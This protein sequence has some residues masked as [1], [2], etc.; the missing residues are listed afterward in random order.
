MF[1]GRA[2][3]DVKSNS[4]TV[5]LTGSIPFLLSIAPKKV[6]TPVSLFRISYIYQNSFLNYFGNVPMERIVWESTRNTVLS[7]VYS[8]DM[9]EI[10][11]STSPPTQRKSFAYA[12]KSPNGYYIVVEAVGGRRNPNV[13]P[14]MLLKFSEAKWNDMMD[15]GKTLGEVL[16]ENDT[17]LRDALDVE[18]N[19]KNRVT[20]AQFASKEAIANTPRSPR[21]EDSIPQSSDS[22]KGESEKT[23]NFYR[24][25]DSVS[26]RPL[27][28]NAFESVAKND[29][30]RR[31]PEEYLCF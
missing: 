26:N 4:F 12:K 27:H 28:A 16:Y 17:E 20:V 10:L 21:L 22:V 11:F 6:F 31:K 5:S 1:L 7:L 8:P 19:K 13:V 23:L 24:S 3:I 15:A 18:F 14:V 29:I 25:A 2:F 30:E 9:V